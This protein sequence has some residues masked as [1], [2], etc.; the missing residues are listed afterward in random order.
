MTKEKVSYNIKLFTIHKFKE[1][2]STTQLEKS[3]QTTKVIS[4]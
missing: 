1:K 2:V 3:N 4:S